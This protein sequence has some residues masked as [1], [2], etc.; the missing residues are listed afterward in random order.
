MHFYGIR[1]RAADGRASES[2]FRAARQIGVIRLGEQG[3]YFR[4]GLKHYYVP[5]ASIKGLFRR[6]MVVPAKMCCGR[7]NFEIEHLVI[8]DEDG[9]AAQIQLPGTRA[10]RE[11]MAELKKRV[12]DADF[13][14]PSRPSDSEG[15]APANTA[16]AQRPTLHDISQ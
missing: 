15:T 7:G 11:L 3:L 13:S 5:Y 12:P 1:S 16:P 8:S 14:A 9:E 4:S 10:A 6:V 2:E